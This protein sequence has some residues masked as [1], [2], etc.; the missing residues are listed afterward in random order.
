VNGLVNGH[1]EHVLLPSFSF[2]ELPGAHAEQLLA[3]KPS[4]LENVFFEQG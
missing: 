2:V 3:I 4:M 1:G